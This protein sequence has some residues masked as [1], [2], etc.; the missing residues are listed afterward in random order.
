MAR[1]DSDE[2]LPTRLPSIGSELLE[3]RDERPVPEK[4]TALALRLQAALDARSLQAGA[5][6]PSSRVKKG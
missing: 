5:A 4:M 3:Y 2:R 6:Q 1:L